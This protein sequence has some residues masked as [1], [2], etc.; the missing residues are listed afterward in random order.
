MGLAM[1]YWHGPAWPEGRNPWRNGH[2]LWEW[3]TRGV[4]AESFRFLLHAS[5]WR[6]HP[7]PFAKSRRAFARRT[8]RKFITRAKRSFL[9]D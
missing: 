5:T 3:H 4:Y 2:T 8:T 7:A 1:R 9:H 6:R